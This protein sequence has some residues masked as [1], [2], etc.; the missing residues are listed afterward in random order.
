MLGNESHF[1][2]LYVS[3]VTQLTRYHIAGVLSSV[4][5]CIYCAPYGASFFL[6]IDTNRRTVD[7][8]DLAVEESG[9][10]MWG[11]GVEALDGCIYFIPHFARK[12]LKLNPV[13]DTVECVGDDLGGGLYVYKYLGIV[14][15]VDGCLY[16]IPF[17]SQRIVKFDPIDH[18]TTLIGMQSIKNFMCGNGV[19]GKDGYI[20]AASAQGQ[21]LRIDTVHDSHSFVGNPVMANHKDRGWGD[22]VV[23][24]DS[25]IYWPPQ[26]SSHVLRYDPQTSKCSLVG[27]DLGNN[28]T[29][30]C[31]GALTTDG[32]V[33][34]IPSNATQVLI[35]DPLKDF[36]R[37]LKADMKQFPEVLGRLFETDLHNGR[38]L[39]EDAVA[40]YGKQKILQIIGEC[41]PS[42]EDSDCFSQ[43]N[44]HPFLSA[45]SCKNSTVDVIYYLLGRNP[46]AISTN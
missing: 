33:Y 13:N 11:A 41:I 35:I 17:T 22:P 44:F 2:F 45:A 46:S 36:V 29:K 5:G 40:K 1:F 43:M 27:E 14:R 7:T 34:C 38:T 21:I 32:A 39:Y 25:C 12:I 16:C 28:S 4:N 3:D 30:Y 37:N 26:N 6:K 18:T 20:Y 9:Y 10:G 19:L 24:T 42:N 31:S 23:G 15:G 8:L